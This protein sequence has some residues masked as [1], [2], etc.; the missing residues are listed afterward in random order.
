MQSGLPPPHKS[1]FDAS[2][3]PSIFGKPSEDPHKA[4]FAQFKTDT[5]SLFGNMPQNNIF[6]NVTAAPSIFNSAQPTEPGK[7]VFGGTSIPLPKPEE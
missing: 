1:L 4:G 6:S 5:P 7:Y 2:S 3:T